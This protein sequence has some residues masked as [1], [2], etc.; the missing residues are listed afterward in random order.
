M[1]TLIDDQYV[2]ATAPVELTPAQRNAAKTWIA[3]QVRARGGKVEIGVLMAQARANT[4]LPTWSRYVTDQ[5]W[6][7]LG[8]ELQAEWD[9]KRAAVAVTPKGL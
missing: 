9:A 7:E 3:A 4:A 8:K 6:L 5:V 2:D 1:L